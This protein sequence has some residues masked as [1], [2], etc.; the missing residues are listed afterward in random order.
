MHPFLD[1][2]PTVVVRAYVHI[3]IVHVIFRLFRFDERVLILAAGVAN[4]LQTD[5]IKNV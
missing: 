5:A 3:P 1:D 4:Y 2:D